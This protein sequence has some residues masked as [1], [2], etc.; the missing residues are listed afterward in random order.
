MRFPCRAAAHA[1]LIPLLLSAVASAQEMRFGRFVR[2]LDELAA[3][4]AV[5]FAPDGTLWVVDRGA[6]QVL[7]FDAD[8]NQVGAFGRR[9][10]GESDLL[11]PAAI[12]IDD[13]GQLYIADAGAHRVLV[14]DA[15]GTP[16]RGWGRFGDAAG[17]FNAPAGI[18]VR[19][20]R[21]YV[22]DQR[23]D[24]VQVFS[25]AGEPDRSFGEHGLAVGQF[26][27]V[28]D[29][30]VDPEGNV[31]TADADAS[32]VQR[33]D[34]HGRCVAAYGEWGFQDGFFSE[35]SGVA[36][37]GGLFFVADQR[38]Q[39]VQVFR[40]DGAFMYK[41]GLHAIRPREGEG[42]LHYPSRVAISPAGDRAAVCEE[43]EGRVQIF[44]L[45][46]AEEAAAE[47]NP[48]A[49][50]EGGAPHF[51]RRL[52][53]SGA[54][55][56]VTEPDNQAIR[57]FDMR[58]P[59]PIMI[60]KFGG[61]GDAPGRFLLPVDLCVDEAAR[62]LL[63]IDEGARRI[64]VF[65]FEWSPEDEVRQLP[66]MTRFVKG[67][68]FK[69][70]TSASAGGEIDPTGAARAADGTMFVIDA[71]RNEIVVF[72]ARFRVTHRFGGY[73]DADGRFLTTADI[74]LADDGQ[75]VV[76]LDSLRGTLQRFSRSGEFRGSVNVREAGALSNPAGFA[77]RPDGG[78][79]V[80]DAGLH[81]IRVYDAE[82]ELLRRWGGEGLGGGEFFKPAGVVVDGQGH[83]IVAD[84]GNHRAQEFDAE[85]KFIR[86]FGAMLYVRPTERP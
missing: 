49:P 25:T 26:I 19:D 1:T 23:N 81:E 21:V 54:L 9:G 65:A 57:V 69:A 46:T 43:F 14:F 80:S 62:R 16:L 63:V 51:G 13:A 61:L 71:H 82:G 37:A 74:A 66:N 44:A 17:E 75:T 86:A 48:L 27:R 3:P 78:A 79:Y 2:Q 24:R 47:F 5:A 15:A 55:L 64:H 18:A 10:F 39:R 60:H 76:V 42:K 20:G 7:A 41:W 6:R 32:R 28:A 31:Y 73:G 33:F 85:G 77:L 4:S 53:V 58:R 45:R 22:A 50:G 38:N 36:W 40:P 12:A 83:V 52:D 30:A 84:Y 8:G 11:S 59:R 68:D 34:P 56:C 29:V 72:D 67:I 35:P 70:V